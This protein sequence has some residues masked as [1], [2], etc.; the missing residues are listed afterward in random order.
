M[1]K[2]EQPMQ[3]DG[4]LSEIIEAEQLLEMAAQ[5][6]ARALVSPQRLVAIGEAIAAR[7]LLSE[8]KQHIEHAT[9]LAKAS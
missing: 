1:A 3:T 9:A 4:A 2:A 7:R 5:T 8:A 6:V